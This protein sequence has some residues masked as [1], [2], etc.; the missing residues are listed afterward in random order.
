MANKTNPIGVRFNKDLLDKVSLSPQKALNLYEEKYLEKSVEPE[1]KQEEPKEP[2]SDERTVILNQIA[3]IKNETI[4]AERNTINGK[5]VW[6]ADQQKRIDY[7]LSK[8][9]SN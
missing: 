4:P 1:T 8:L 7:L 9:L 6:A 2:E 3:A 5:K